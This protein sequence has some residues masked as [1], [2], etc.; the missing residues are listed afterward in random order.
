MG[1]LS[2]VTINN[3]GFVFGGFGDDGYNKQ[4]FKIS[5][6]NKD[7]QWST[8]DKVLDNGRFKT[9]AIPISTT[10]CK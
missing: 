8:T 4:V 1:G 6:A 9:V 2:I 3:D 10:L 7:C 5:C